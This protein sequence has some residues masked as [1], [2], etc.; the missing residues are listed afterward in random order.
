MLA[1]SSRLSDDP[2]SPL[3]KSPGSE[4]RAGV[5][6]RRSRRRGLPD[7][8]AIDT[9]LEDMS[10]V[11][12]HQANII[13]QL[14]SALASDDLSKRAVTLARVTD[15]FVRE[16]DGLRDADVELFGEVM[17][18]LM[19]GIEAAARAQFGRRIARL[20]RAPEKVVWDLAFDSA[21]EVAG[22][23]LSESVLLGDFHLVENARTKSQAHLLA[24]SKR[25]TLSTRVTDILV[26]RGNPA[27]LHSTARNSG[28]AFS[29]LGVSILVQKSGAD[30]DLALCVW[31]RPDIPRPDLIRI[32][33][34]ASEAVRRE[35]E[36]AT[37][38]RAEVLRVAIAEA[39]GDIQSLARAGSK[40]A[41]D[42]RF[43]VQ[44]LHALGQL[45][46]AVLLDI[47]NAGKFDETAV[48]LSLMCDLPIGLV[49]R[50]LVQSRPQ[51]V[52][53]IAKSFSLSWPVCKALVLLQPGDESYS[54]ERLDQIFASYT[55]MPV[56]TA[57]AALEFYRSQERTHDRSS[58][59]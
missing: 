48:A 40:T 22:P 10:L 30:G 7:G 42:A 9:R 56:K 55:R 5:G 38:E 8:A 52:I 34:Q 39:T 37:P 6:S 43:S 58:V 14:Q 54:K 26:Y 33:V 4:H 31:S 59:H 11:M 36:A 24:I 49:E 25:A 28:A 16:S 27:V 21:I 47:I 12:T 19:Y 15:L 46:E 18:K 29:E 50:L 41:R 3:G 1:A 32:F 51:Q 20:S 44:R 57:R 35:M 17:T 13:D 53:I 45:N 2:Q 23:V